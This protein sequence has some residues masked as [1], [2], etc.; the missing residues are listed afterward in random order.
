MNLLLK[1]LAAK[2]LYKSY[3]DF[4]SLKKQ[5]THLMG[6]L[7]T[8]FSFRAP[9]CPP[10]TSWFE[11]FVFPCSNLFQ[12]PRRAPDE[13]DQLGNDFFPG[14]FLGGSFLGPISSGKN[15]KR[16]KLLVVYSSSCHDKLFVLGGAFLVVATPNSQVG[17]HCFPT[18]AGSFVVGLSS[19]D[20]AYSRWLLL[21]TY[22]D[23]SCNRICFASYN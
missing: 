5:Q 14:V 12:K 19:S 1:T 16:K 4:C 3:Y 11:S 20:W 23:S 9:C 7:C 10:T 15:T 13:L 17:H 18:E 8:V 2:V 21:G 6:F 22:K